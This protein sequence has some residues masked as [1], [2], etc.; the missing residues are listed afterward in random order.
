MNEFLV[1][2]KVVL[3]ALLVTSGLI[4]ETRNYLSALYHRQKPDE[5][6]IWRFKDDLKILSYHDLRSGEVNPEVVRDYQRLCDVRGLEKVE[7]RHRALLS[8]KQVVRK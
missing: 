4:K 7:A 5:L 1:S 2:R 8:F 6:S 3:H